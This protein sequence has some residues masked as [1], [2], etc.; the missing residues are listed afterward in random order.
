[1]KSVYAMIL[2]FLGISSAMWAA[3][4]APG[5]CDGV[6]RIELSQPVRPISPLLYGIFYE[7]INHAADGGLYAELVRNRTFEDTVPP[8]GCKVSRNKLHTPAGW[9][10]P[11]PSIDPL[12]GWKA[13][14]DGGMNAEMGLAAQ[15]WRTEGASRAVRVTVTGSGPGFGGIANEGYWGIPVVSGKAYDFFMIARGEDGFSGPVEVRLESVAGAVY[16]VETIAKLG[17]VWE[18]YPLT[19]KSAG[20][21]EQARLVIA[22]RTA[23]SFG[24]GMV[25]LFPQQTWKGRP[26]EL[27]VDLAE[28]LADM[29]PA[30]I[31]FPGGCFVE[32]FTLDTALRWKKTIGPIENRPGHWNLW[33]YRSTNGLGYHELLQL[34]ADLGAEPLLVINCGM[35]CQGRNGE[36]VPM[37]ALEPWVQDALDAIE[38]ANGPADSKWGAVRA[39]AGHPEPFDLNYI[40]VGNEN[41]GPLYE[42]RYQRFYNAIKAAYPAMQ[43][44]S[45][46][47]VQSAPADIIDEHYYNSP[48]FFVQQSAKYD[49]YDRGGP[50]IYVGEYAVVNGCGKGNL[51]A[52]VAEA[53]FMT[54]MER[55]GDKVVMASY[56]PLF[57]HTEDRCWNPD[58][59]VFDN[60]RSYGTPSYHVQAMFSRARAD[61]AFETR[62]ETGKQAWETLRGGIGLSTWQTQAEFKDVVVTD[63]TGKTLYASDFA[64]STQEWKVMNG[65]WQVV[66]G[67]YRQS[68]AGMDF[69]TIT[70]DPSWSKYTLQLKAR[71]LGGQEG[72]L[73]LFGARDAQNWFWWNLG[74]WGNAQHGVEMMRNGAKSDA[75][76]RVPGTIESGR[77]YDIR[78]ELTENQVRCLLDGKVIHEFSVPETPYLAATAGRR[79]SDGAV[80]V[81]LVNAAEQAQTVRIE[82]AGAKAVAATGTAEVLQSAHGDDENTL[83]APDNVSPK[84]QPMEGVGPVFTRTVPGQSVTIMTLNAQ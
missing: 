69:R 34:C 26:T 13:V 6:L 74:G 32:G 82:L 29:H 45:N 27:R 17:S 7:D 54:G 67:A 83:D 80:I 35:S 81:K 33:G 46:V 8:E 25:S 48:D 30:F 42:E 63:A 39:A 43:I 19:L 77:W 65:L 23:G 20:A 49:T 12:P 44:I 76:P 56:A 71:K 62:L 61:A 52:A 73:I 22:S 24:V 51:R 4:P 18:K 41:S 50:R 31:R 84:S 16:A 59:I 37:D 2:M 72:F 70:G 38:Y 11:F 64:Q 14:K 66:D 53:A 1:M 3:E 58:A 78:V 36:V 40:E 10:A 28:K 75:S 55:N 60:H 15:G 9:T 68:G 79:T 57:V 47:A 5:A 21:D